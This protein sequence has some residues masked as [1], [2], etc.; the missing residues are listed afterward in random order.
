VG[1]LGTEPSSLLLGAHEVYP[2]GYGS[3]IEVN[4]YDAI[5]VINNL[6]GRIE[7][8]DPEIIIVGSQSQSVPFTDSSLKYLPIAQHEF[9]LATAPDCF[10]LCINLND[11][12]LYIKRTIIYLESLFGGK[13]LALATLPLDHAQKWSVIS[14]KKIIIPK[15]EVRLKISQIK[16]FLSLDVYDISDED[17]M[18]NLTENVVNHFANIE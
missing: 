16:N 9:L 10:I 7:D 15:E 17:E 4:G 12:L 14:N 18:I 11:E 3:T 8:I 1:M 2:M 6:L 5:K 13:V